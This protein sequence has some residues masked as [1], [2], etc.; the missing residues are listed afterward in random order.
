MI[1]ES[2]RVSIDKNIALEGVIIT[3]TCPSG[4]TLVGDNTSVC[5]SNGQWQPDPRKVECRG[6]IINLYQ[7]PQYYYVSTIL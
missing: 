2:V 3:Y 4:L 7:I 1:G 5:L 6:T